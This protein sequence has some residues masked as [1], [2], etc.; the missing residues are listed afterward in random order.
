MPEL[1]EG[2]N[3]CSKLNLQKLDQG[4]SCCKKPKKPEARPFKAQ[5][6]EL[7]EKQ[8][9]LRRFVNNFFFTRQRS[10]AESKQTQNLERSHLIEFPIHRMSE[11]SIWMFHRLGLHSNQSF[12]STRKGKV[13]ISQH[14]KN[15]RKN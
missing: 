7:A 15:K 8:S 5:M 3:V 13:M 1:F 9:V 14:S 10:D 6:H 11:T 12:S 2:P 4:S